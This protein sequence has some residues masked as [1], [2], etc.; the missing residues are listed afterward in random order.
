MTELQQLSHCPEFG[1]S[2]APP[3]S[4]LSVLLHLLWLHPTPGQTSPSSRSCGC[5]VTI[6]IPNSVYPL[7]NSFPNYVLPHLRGWHKCHSSHA[8]RRPESHQRRDLLNLPAT[9][10]NAPQ[11]LPSEPPLLSILS[12]GP[13]YCFSL[14]F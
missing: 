2:P 8:C 11:S 13:L 4:P 3:L 5:W 10:L 7:F 14:G 12:Q 9:V 6:D 1:T